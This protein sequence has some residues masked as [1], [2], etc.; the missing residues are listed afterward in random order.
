MAKDAIICA[1]DIG[2]HT[3]RTVIAQKRKGNDKLSIIGL[4][5]VASSGLDHPVP[6]GRAHGLNSSGLAQTHRHHRDLFTAFGSDVRQRPKNR[7]R[8][9]PAVPRGLKRSGRGHEIASLLGD[10]T[11]RC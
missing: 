10:T 8:E 5:E 9:G 3:F 11:G 6:S 4:G 2:S 7:H 1:L